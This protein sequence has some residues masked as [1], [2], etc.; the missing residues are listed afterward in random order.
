MPLSTPNSLIVIIATLSLITMIFIV[1]FSYIFLGKIA[2]L[3]V[4][5]LPFFFA[6]D[7]FLSPAESEPAREGN[8]SKA[9]RTMSRSEPAF[10]IGVGQET[11]IPGYRLL[12]TASLAC[13]TRRIGV[14]AVAG[15]RGIPEGTT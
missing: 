12:G 3:G 13:E 4:H 7:S 14:G 2:F 1:I 9:T 5:S 11:T 6:A 15:G 8:P 10:L